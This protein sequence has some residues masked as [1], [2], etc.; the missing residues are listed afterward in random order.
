MSTFQKMKHQKNQK[1]RLCLYYLGGVE[2]VVG[3]VVTLSTFYCTDDRLG[4]SF[5]NSRH[6]IHFLCSNGGTSII[7]IMFHIFNTA[8]NDNAAAFMQRQVV[9]AVTLEEKLER[10]PWRKH[11]CGSREL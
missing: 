6:V 8:L 3:V 4:H 7:R 11:L 5:C 2:P 9:V 1:E 10:K